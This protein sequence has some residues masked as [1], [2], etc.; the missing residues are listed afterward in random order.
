MAVDDAGGETIPDL[1]GG[2]IERMEV[3]VS[4]RVGDVKFVGLS[5]GLTGRGLDGAS[6]RSDVQES[7]HDFVHQDG[8]VHVAAVLQRLEV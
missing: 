8:L 7:V 1:Y 6:W 5:S 4:T 3:G 2:G